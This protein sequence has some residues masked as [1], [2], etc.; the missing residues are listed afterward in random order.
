VVLAVLVVGG[1]VRGVG[2]FRSGVV[3]FLLLGVAELVLWSVVVTLL[4]SAAV[5]LLL[6]GVVGLV[7]RSVVVTLLLSVRGCSF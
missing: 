5:T 7:F 4:L 6:L 2:W 3:L 1:V